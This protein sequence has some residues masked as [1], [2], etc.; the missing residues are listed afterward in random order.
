M[1]PQEVFTPNR[2][3]EHTYV[4]RR[5][6]DLEESLQFGLDTPGEIV[7]LAGPSKSGKTVLVRKVVGEDYLI[8]VQGAGISSPADLWNSVLDWMDAPSST[9]ET[10]G[11]S[12]GIG[13]NVDA[14]G[15]L[16]IPGIGGGSV[17]G[18]VKGDYSTRREFLKQ[19][20]RR[21]LHQIVEDIANSEFVILV[22]DFHYIDREAQADIAEAIKEA[23]R[24]EVS[25]CVA[26][27]PHR[28]DDL[29]RANDDL[30][31]RVRGLEID[32]WEQ[33]DL[34]K[35]AYKGFEVLGIDFPEHAI[36]SFAQEA[37]GSPQLMQLLCLQACSELGI[38]EEGEE[39]TDIS[40]EAEDI[41]EIFRKS[42]EYADH[43]STFQILDSGPKPR[44]TERKIYEFTD[45]NT[46][47]V[48]RCLLRAIASDPP[49]LSFHYDELKE[50]TAQQ[51]REEKPSGSSITGS[52][53]Q[54]EKEIRDSFPQVRAIEWDDTKQFLDI[55][56]PYLLF[57]LRWSGHL[58][59]RP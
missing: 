36:E 15:Q 8:V 37:A 57:Y 28:S 9:E 51:C 6:R 44:G 12:S 43:E 4:K 1:K 50:R 46:G 24:E 26:L 32:Y 20:S 3:P 19:K 11:S 40:L 25:V 41:E 58:E 21:G 18:S 47:D 42:A 33:H 2:Y 7:S 34:K 38:Q 17:K 53:S 54:M 16:D 13:G 31:G 10:S 49:K 22:D 52:C 55:P 56:D 14:E 35:I 5:D 48:Y 23:A 30:R 39:E 29:V 27:V 59:N 45:G